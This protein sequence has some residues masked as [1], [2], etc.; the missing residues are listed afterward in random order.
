MSNETKL[1]K[2]PSSGKYRKSS[3]LEVGQSIGG[4]LI[5]FRSEFSE[6]L[7]KDMTSIVLKDLNTGK[8]FELSPSGT[9]NDAIAAGQLKVGLTYR[10]EKAGVEKTKKG[11]YKNV[12]NIYQSKATPVAEN[13]GNDL[14]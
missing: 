11:A 14:E 1:P 13:N 4:T 12:F 5:G 6:A 9:I 2:A 10:F 3:E 7:K 8:E